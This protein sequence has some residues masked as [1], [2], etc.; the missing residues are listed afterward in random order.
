M[1]KEKSAMEKLADMI[2]ELLPKALGGK[3]SLKD[4]VEK[5]R[6]STILRGNKK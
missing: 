6:D 4:K 1:P 2:K 3:S 5:A